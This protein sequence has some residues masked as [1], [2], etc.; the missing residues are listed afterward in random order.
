[1]PIVPRGEWV[2]MVSAASWR[3][4]S[5]LGARTL[6]WVFVDGVRE[7][8]ITWIAMLRFRTSPT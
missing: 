3:K 8:G 2:G 5:P 7:P 1:M 6:V 4:F